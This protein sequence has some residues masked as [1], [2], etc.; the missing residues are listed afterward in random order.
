MK[1]T[2]HVG[3]S[4]LL[5]FGLVTAALPSF[6]QD[7]PKQAKTTAEYNAYIAFYQEKDPAK[8]AALG[9]KFI[10]DFKESDYIPDAHMGV[11]GGYANSKN[12]PKVT[13]SA[14]KAIAFPAADN[15]LKAYA[16]FNAMVAAQNTNEVD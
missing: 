5:L 7:K 12:W 3:L 11:I 9:E 2:G 8:K 13:E 1:R 6:G 10:Q 16:N 4:L 15:K 14:E